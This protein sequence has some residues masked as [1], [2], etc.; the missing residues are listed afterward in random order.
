[1]NNML[2]NRKKPVKLACLYICKMLGLFSL[3]RWVTRRGVRILCYH[4]VWLGEDKFAGDAMFMTQACFERRLDLL[5][6]LGYSVISLSAAAD[7]ICGRGA[8]PAGSVVI[9]IDDG[10]YSSMYML[11]ALGHRDM[12]ATLYCDTAH[13]QAGLP[14]AHVM[15]SYLL[16]I[17]HPISQDGVLLDNCDRAGDRSLA[18]ETRLE[19]ARNVA[20]IAGI[21]ADEYLE[22]RAF[23]YM[24][25]KELRRIADS[26]FDIQLHTHR[27]T[28]HD[29][30]REWLRKEIGDNRRELAQILGRDP[31][32]FRHF[33]YPSG[34]AG[35]HLCEQL[36]QLGIQSSTTTQTGLAWPGANKHLLPRILDGG[37]LCAIEFE[38]EISGFNELIR[39]LTRP[40]RRL[41]MQRSTFTDKKSEAGYGT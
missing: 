41:A 37:H 5:V 10:W 19:A 8:I 32:S 33:C 3:A 39:P 34:I 1:M 16:K 23:N 35:E 7:A 11:N 25:A 40:L 2:R 21:D 18:I 4:A 31:L 24:T 13:L 30:S 17:A 36:D 20:T 14:V 38:A 15:A 6:R 27:H 9:T 12:V 26:G 29:L 22:R 28:M